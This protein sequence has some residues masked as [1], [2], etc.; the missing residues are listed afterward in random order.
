MLIFNINLYN[1][2]G[3]LKT[4]H[5]L[6]VSRRGVVQ[7]TQC[8]HTAQVPAVVEQ[9]EQVCIGGRLSPLAAPL[10]FT[11]RRISR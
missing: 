11:S 9:I 3:T 2:Y 4:N 8:T 10:F 5:L 7:H 6:L 1:N